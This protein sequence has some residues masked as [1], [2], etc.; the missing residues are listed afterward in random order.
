MYMYRREKGES[1]GYTHGEGKVMDTHTLM[2]VEI[3]PGTMKALA[4]AVHPWVNLG[5]SRGLVVQLPS[6]MQQLMRTGVLPFP[7]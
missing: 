6:T 2:R 7:V 3:R 5:Q 1:K 4:R